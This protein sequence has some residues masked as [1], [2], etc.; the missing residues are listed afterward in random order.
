MKK[1]TISF[2]LPV[3][4]LLVVTVL[5]C[6]PGTK[7][8]K[9]DWQAKI[10]LDKWVHVG[11]F[12][13]LVISWCWAS[14]GGRRITNRP[15]KKIFVTITILTIF[16]GIC[17]EII[18]HYFIPFRSFDYKDILANAAGSLIGYFISVKRYASKFSS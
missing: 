16:Y 5:Y 3:F 9:I 12:L 7:F 13:L 2:V 14:S 11:L 6:I 17:M 10:W 15:L 18:Q 8:P 1:T 4:W